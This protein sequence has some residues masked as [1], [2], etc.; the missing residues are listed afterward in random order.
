MNRLGSDTAKKELVR[1]AAR[2]LNG[3]VT[4]ADVVSVTGLSSF[5]ATQLL[6][7]IAL[8]TRGNLQVTDDGKL[9]YKF[10]ADMYSSSFQKALA[11][12]G[13]TMSLLL[14]YGLM[15]VQFLFGALLIISITFTSLITMIALTIGG[16]MG[17]MR[18][19]PAPGFNLFSML[20]HITRTY[21]GKKVATRSVSGA[22]RLLELCFRFIFGPPDP[23]GD[24]E[25]YHWKM[26][27][28]RIASLNGI[29]CEDELL[30]FLLDPEHP[31]KELLE[32]AVRFDGIPECSDSGQIIYRFPSLQGANA[33]GLSSTEEGD[34][35][36]ENISRSTIFLKE[37]LWTFSGTKFKETVP[38]IGLIFGN[39]CFCTMLNCL[40]Q[41]LPWFGS[42]GTIWWT[43]TLLWAYA[44]LILL[45]P[46]CRLPLI[47]ARNKGVVARNEAR[48]N[49]VKLL[50]APSQEV[51][52]RLQ[53]AQY[54]RFNQH[55]SAIVYTTESNY[56]EQS[57][58]S[59]NP[60]RGFSV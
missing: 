28:R 31:D 27:A 16:A 3:V 38:V 57:D 18:A 5:E 24:L 44:C 40:V 23:N 45:F 17:G 9:I 2:D 60:N 12:T 21:S 22:E 43:I 20:M 4:V 10:D 26:I 49:A 1:C 39:F 25:E 51:A 6:N 36:L 54:I 58:R 34:E 59:W 35:S 15:L 33:Q 47:A 30:P 42:F 50:N 56:L 29:V 14:K 46:V 48:M 13:R 37:G 32:T 19:A 53:E 8:E 55:Q 11:F 7:H 41:H 52:A